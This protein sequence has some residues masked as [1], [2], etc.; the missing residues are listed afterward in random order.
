MSTRS[1]RILHIFKNLRHETM[2]LLTDFYHPEVEFQDPL[3]AINGL[4]ALHDYYRQMYEGVQSID[5]TFTD[6][7][8]QGDHHVVMWIMRVQAKKLNGGKPVEV[9]GN[10]S[11]IFDGAT[12]QAI[13]HRD[14]FDMGAF[15][16]EHVPVLGWAIDKIK[17]RLSANH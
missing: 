8:V 15:I 13:Y 5:F 4:P 16:Y 14:Y 7:V 6:E 9:T 17:R 10:S 3:G 2:G 12:D 11:I 1:E